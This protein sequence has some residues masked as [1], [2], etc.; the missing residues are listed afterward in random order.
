MDFEIKTESRNVQ[1]TVPQLSFARDKK[2]N[3][4]RA[5]VPTNV[6]SP[7]ASVLEMIFNRPAR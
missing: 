4:G 3:E 7:L 2:I 6:E 1:L 5:K